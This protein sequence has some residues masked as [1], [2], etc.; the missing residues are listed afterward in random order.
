MLLHANHASQNGYKTT[1]IVSEDTDVMILCLG[2]C[3]EINCAMYLKCGTHNRTRYINMSSL[4][5]LHGDDLCDALVGVHAFTGCDSAAVWSH[6]LEGQPDIP[7]PNR[8]GWKT[9]D[10]GMLMLDWMRGPPA[11]MAV[12]ELMACKCGRPCKLP[13]CSCLANKLKCTEM[14]KLQTCT[15]QREEDVEVAVTLDDYDDDDN[16][17]DDD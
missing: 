3:K 2:H 5:E 11:P 14:C 13:D 4:A 9:D 6:C 17:D 15:N 8:H 10:K 16:D 12:L 1:V 7:E